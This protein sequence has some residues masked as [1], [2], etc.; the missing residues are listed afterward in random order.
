MI[1]C[2]CLDFV[3]G[4]ITLFIYSYGLG[5]GPPYGLGLLFIGYF[6]AFLFYYL[7]V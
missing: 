2:Y 4:G 5:V 7:P 3:V 1:R 6:S